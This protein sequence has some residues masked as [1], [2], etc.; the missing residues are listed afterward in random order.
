MSQDHEDDDELTDEP[1]ID[2]ENQ[3]RREYNEK[4][5]DSGD[6]D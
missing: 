4:H 3:R 1:D 5:F 2:M 6:S